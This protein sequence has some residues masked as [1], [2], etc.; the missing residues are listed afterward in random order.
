MGNKESNIQSRIHQRN[1]KRNRHFSPKINGDARN[2]AS[3]LGITATAFTI[4]WKSDKNMG[5][6]EFSK[7]LNSTIE[8]MD[9]LK[10]P[11][12]LVIAK[13]NPTMLQCYEN[14]ALKYSEYFSEAERKEFL[15]RMQNSY[16]SA[17]LPSNLNLKAP[18][19]ST[20]NWLISQ[21]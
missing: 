7:L 3:A 5:R 18:I 8:S 20:I 17:S 10:N 9:E 1:S 12:D 15:T 2:I 4:M 21:S 6:N 11:G 16:F 14:N 19:N 13:R